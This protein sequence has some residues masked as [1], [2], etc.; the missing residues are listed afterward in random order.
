MSSTQLDLPVLTS[1]Q[2]PLCLH[3]SHPS[4]GL[5]LVETCLIAGAPV[6]PEYPLAPILLVLSRQVLPST[7]PLH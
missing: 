5:F 6:W 4:L 3:T 7:H 1:G 2:G